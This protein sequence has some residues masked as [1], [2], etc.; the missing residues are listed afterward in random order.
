MN[1]K[2]LD[3][4]KCVNCDSQLKDNI[5]KEVLECTNCSSE[6]PII[7]KVPAF[8]YNALNNNITAK[9]F[10]EQWTHYKNGEYEEDEVFGLKASDYLEHFCYAF[11]IKNIHDFEGTI[12]EV[13]V[14]SGHL[15]NVLAQNAPKATIIGMDISDNIFKLSNI[16]SKYPNVFLIQGDLLNP[17]IKKFSIKYIYSSGVIHHTKSVYGSIKSL[18]GLLKDN[19]GQLYFW[20]YPSY[21]YCAYDRLRNMLGKPYLFKERTRYILSK[22]LAPFLWVYFFITKKYSY[23]ISL[24]SLK[25]VSFRIFDNISPEFQHRVSKE[26]IKEYCEKLNITNYTIK[27]DLGVLCI[28]DKDE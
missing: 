25:T 12:L 19:N 1:S 9:A 4:Y 23:K 10:S 6:Y 11:N 16:M 21:Q 2:I 24:E 7:N 22:I 8:C 14:G 18:W 3:L 5:E 17:P 15:I 27:N 13:G 28:K 26:E 20:I